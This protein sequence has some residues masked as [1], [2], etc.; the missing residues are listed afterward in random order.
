MIAKLITYS[1]LI[2]RL[3]KEK[4]FSQNFWIKMNKYMK[5]VKVRLV[6]FCIL[7]LVITLFC[8]FFNGLFCKIYK[9]FLPF[10]KE[11]VFF[12]KLPLDPSRLI[13]L[14]LFFQSP[15]DC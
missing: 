9:G 13:E 15:T 2:E 8:V 10:I 7:E 14:L 1:S 6:F 3:L 4:N 12:A 11:Y 5:I